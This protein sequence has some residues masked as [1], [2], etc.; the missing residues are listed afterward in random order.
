LALAL[1]I[2]G[3]SIVCAILLALFSQIS[4][5]LKYVFSLCALVLG[6]RFFRNYDTL[7]HRVAF[8]ALT[9][10]FYFIVN[11][12]YVILALQNGWPVHE[13]YHS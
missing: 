11:I 13:Q 3:Y 4:D 1:R 5:I 12:V 10:V 6:I 8:I 7:G 2:V 9:I